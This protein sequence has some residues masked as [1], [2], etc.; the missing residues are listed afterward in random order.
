MGFGYDCVRFTQPRLLSRG[1]FMP[2]SDLL[3]STSSG[4][5]LSSIFLYALD[6]TIVADLQTVL[7]NEFS[8]IDKFSWLSVGLLL[9]ATTTNMVWGRIYTQFNSKWLYIF[10]VFL[11]EAG[12]AICGSAPNIDT[13]IVGR[14]ICGVGGS[15]LYVGVMTLIAATTTIKERP[16]YISGTGLT[17]GLG[18]VLGPIIGGAFVQS[19]VGWRWAFYINLFIGGAAAPAYLFLLPSIDPRPGVPLKKRVAEIDHFGIVL[20]MGA[21]VAFCLA[22]NWGGVVYAW[23]SGDVIGLFVASGV[24]FALLGVQQAWS[25]FTTVSRRII[26]FQF[27]GSRTVL[28]LFSVTAASGASAFVPIYMVPTFFQFVRSDSALEGGVR[29]LPLIVV[30]VVAIFANGALLSN[31]GYY[32]P[33]YTLGGLLVAAGG[34]L[35]YTVDQNTS[36]SRIYGYTV[37]LGLGVGMF[38]QASFAVAQAIVAVED[39]PAAVGFMTLAQYTGI[40]IA[41]AIANTLYLNSSQAKISQIL[42]DISMAEIQAAMTGVSGGFLDKLSPRVRAQVLDAIVG[43]IDQ[44]YILVTAAGSLVAVLSLFMKREKLF[45]SSAVAA[46]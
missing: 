35:M 3:T 6:A 34:A 42:P 9:G 31:F 11:F 15:G 40:T 14:V 38:L 32:M 18:I 44:T 2:Y 10:N 24:L 4:R 26:P 33:W 21:L 37:I 41:L 23:N 36:D 16:L 28:I 30:M 19:S 46:A 17:W 45:V 1:T 22:I 25:L 7:V 12:S 27:F 39:V 5:I 43:S 8:G 20:L 13:L 29:L